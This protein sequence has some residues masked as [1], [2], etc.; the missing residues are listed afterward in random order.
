MILSV[1]TRP[2]LKYS[3]IALVILLA[4]PACEELPT[5]QEAIDHL[6]MTPLCC[7]S[8]SEINFSPFPADSL[9][10][11]TINNSLPAFEFDTGKS[12]FVAYELP[13]QVMPYR[14]IINSY[15]V[16]YGATTATIFEPRLTLLDADYNIL[17]S[18]APG[19]FHFRRLGLAE[20]FKLTLSTT[21]ES[22]FYEGA[23]VVDDPRAKYVIIYSSIHEIEAGVP[24]EYMQYAQVYTGCGYMVPLPMGKRQ[25]TIAH[26]PYGVFRMMAVS[27]NATDI[28]L[29]EQFGDPVDQD[30]YQGNGF[31]IRP[32]Q[33]DGYRF[34]DKS[35][36]QD[37]L[38]INRLY[39]VTAEPNGAHNEAYV[40]SAQEMVDKGTSM[41]ELLTYAIENSTLV[42]S[43]TYKDYTYSVS[44]MTLKDVDCRR[45]DY[46]YTARNP[47][48][49]IDFPSRGY[50][51]YCIHP[52][53]KDAA[54]RLV[55]RIGAIK[56]YAYGE[57]TEDFPAE[58]SDFFKHVQF[59]TVGEKVSE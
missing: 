21:I 14:I 40:F 11:I 36:E 43:R 15:P 3:V 26:S 52:E 16:G 13:D 6:E 39:F 46:S 17:G 44:D 47:F 32:P 54:N 41:D 19:T 31:T 7:Q 4:L 56:G 22:M 45:I 18:T 59:D 1:L 48:L 55:I 30:S 53:I 5:R 37:E 51:I 2:I 34:A 12:H 27:M 20:G 57:S 28:S 50:D 23:F 25:T 38:F 10:K 8:K 58:L 35:S 29:C 49:L 24:Y 33:A 9:E 42:Q